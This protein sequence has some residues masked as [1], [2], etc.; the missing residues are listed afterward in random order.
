MK[1]RIQEWDGSTSVVT[2]RL[3]D[4]GSVTIIYDDGHEHTVFASYFNSI[5]V[6]VL[7]ASYLMEKSEFP[8]K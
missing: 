3:N 4:D 1:F 7:S 5:V 8:G 6:E 2:K